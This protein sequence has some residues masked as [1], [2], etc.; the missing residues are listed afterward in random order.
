[1]WKKEK[2]MIVNLFDNEIQIMA[3]MK[4]KKKNNFL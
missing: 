4:L 1:M 2:D 3:K